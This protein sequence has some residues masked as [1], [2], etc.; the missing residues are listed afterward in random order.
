MAAE[1]VKLPLRHG[2]KFYLNNFNY[3]NKS[4]VRVYVC[5]H[6]YV[7]NP[8]QVK[9]TLIKAQKNINTPVVIVSST[10]II[11]WEGINKIKTE[12]N[13]KKNRKKNVNVQ[14]G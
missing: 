3:N 8:P 12:N 13:E 9:M 1:Y 6:S 5:R 2:I 10:I 14:A 7:L 4:I 11:T